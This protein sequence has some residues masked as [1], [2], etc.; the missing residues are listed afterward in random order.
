MS[1]NNVNCIFCSM[2]H[3][4][5]FFSPFLPWKGMISW[6]TIENN[7]SVKRK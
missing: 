7:L 1:D 3:S 5:F 6:Q 4:R 2:S